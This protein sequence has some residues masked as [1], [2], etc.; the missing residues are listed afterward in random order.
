MKRFLT[1]CLMSCALLSLAGCNFYR[2]TML[3]AQ[4]VNGKAY[5]VLSTRDAMSADDL[6]LFQVYRSS[7]P[8][9]SAWQA[10][11][12]K[13]TGP[14]F[15]TFV[16]KNDSGE[17]LGLFHRQ[18][19]S[20]WSFDGDKVEVETLVLP[21]KW[22]AETS[23][24][25]GDTLYV[26]G[27]KLDLQQARETR[28]WKG[29]LA[30]S[31]YDDSEFVELKLGPVFQAGP[32]GAFQMQAVAHQGKILVFWRKAQVKGQ[33]DREVSYAG[34]LLMA[35]F[36]PKNKEHEFGHEVVEFPGLPQGHVEV[37]SDGTEL[38]AVVQPQEMG[39]GRTPQL[40]LFGLT[41]G[42]E[43]HEKPMAL[44]EAPMR[45][46]FKFFNVTRLNT[47]GRMAFIR[48]NTQEF[49]VWE[50]VSGSWRVN[51]KPAGLP[52]QQLMSLLWLMMVLCVSLVAMGVGMA[53]RRRRQMRW[54]LQKLRPQDV[55]AP[56]SLRI[57]AYLIDLAMVVGLTMTLCA[58]TGLKRP[59]WLGVFMEFQIA[60]V[61]AAVY[62][63]YLTVT[64]WQLGRTLGKWLLGIQV[65]T[66]QGDP[67]TLWAS[68][69]RNLIGFFE[70]HLPPA[71]IIAVLLT[72]RAQRLGDLMGRTLVV[73][74]VAF[75]RYREQRRQ[76]DAEKARAEAEKCGE[77][78]PSKVDVVVGKDTDDAPSTDDESKT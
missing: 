17:R 56:L 46:H 27:G 18:R 43:A 12:D 31:C 1:T 55:L 44:Y 69:V 62:V 54:V 71:A 30:A 72:P 57:S 75:E 37:W 64:E 4:T 39:S 33:I 53:I 36:D 78:E 16:Y 73:Q 8:D 6:G 34:P 5:I 41:V 51:H 19:I 22:L 49:E 52:R 32:G 58:A 13:R 2:D 9:F 76:A 24:Q 26:F 3:P 11:D 70:R 35:T 38:Q 15:G 59:S 65:V 61:Y 20:L 45:L 66:D 28:V 25:L 77:D 23:A 63:A 74:R 48:S 7:A 50:P 21:F 68:F 40:K 67:P 14:V 29:R 10:L 60:E 42:G 47:E